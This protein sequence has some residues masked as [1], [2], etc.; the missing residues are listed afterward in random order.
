M[1]L[2]EFII[3]QII[4]GIGIVFSILS[5]QQKERKYYLLCQIV[6]LMMFIIQLLMLGGYTGAVVNTISLIRAIVFA[7]SEKKWA[8]SP[9][10][11]F[12]FALALTVAGI[13]TWQNIWSILPIIAALLSTAAQWMKKTKHSRIISLFVSPCWLTYDLIHGSF[14]G[15]LNEILA[16]TSIIIGIIRHDINKKESHNPN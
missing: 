11:P 12:I 8:S 13:L 1:T 14:S 10:L 4:G 16:L 2:V 5:F 7:C 15:I 6:T 3:A 9:A